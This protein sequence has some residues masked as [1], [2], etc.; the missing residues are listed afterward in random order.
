MAEK[1][2]MSE[3]LEDIYAADTD[4][5]MLVLVDEPYKGTVDA[6]SAKRIYQFGKDVAGYPQLLLALATHV[7]KPIA[8][9]QDAPGIFGNYQ[10][11]INETRLG[12][13]ERLFKLEPGP[14]MW[15]FDDGDKRSRFVDWIST[16][17]NVNE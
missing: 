17:G 10:V 16:K 12:T 9:A 4:D 6:E 11:K 7:R 5:K 14:A 3:L 8:L 2:T 1:K 15:W 13:F